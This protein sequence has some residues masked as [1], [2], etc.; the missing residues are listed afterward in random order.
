MN[1]TEIPFLTHEIG[2][3]RKP[4]AFIKAGR[5]QGLTDEDIFNFDKF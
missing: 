1:Y 2:S 3:L 4:T 5:N